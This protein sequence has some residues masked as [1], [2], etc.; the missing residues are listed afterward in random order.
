MMVVKIRDYEVKSIGFSDFLNISGGSERRK[1]VTY[2]L[3]SL[4]VT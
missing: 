4:V 2:Q 3:S 1:K